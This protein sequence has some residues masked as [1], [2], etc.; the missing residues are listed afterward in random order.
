MKNIV[1]VL[2]HMLCGG[3]EKSL[4][5]LINEMPKDKYKITIL[6]V[7]A[8]GEFIE[9]IPDYVTCKELPI[10]KEIR[11]DLMLGG[12]K[13]SI[14]YH[15]KTGN[16]I[17]MMKVICN[18]ILKEPLATLTENFKNIEPIKEKYDI[19]ICYH[20][21]MPFIVRYVSEK[22]DAR[23]K[24]AWVHND[25]GNSGYKIQN[26]SKYME[27][28]DHCFCVSEQ[29]FNEFT[30]LLPSLN[31]KTS[32]SYNIISKRYIMDLAQEDTSNKFT[33][34]KSI[35]I[36]TIGR[37]DHQKGYD[38]AIKVCKNIINQGYQIKWFVL[39]SGEDEKKIRDMINEYNLEQNFILLGTRKNPYPYI[40]QCDI[41]VQTSRHEGYGIAIAEARV[42]CKAIVCT[43]FTGAREQIINGKTGTIVE[44][45]ENKITNEIIELIR[46]KEKR[47]YYENNLLMEQCDSKGEINNFLKNI[48]RWS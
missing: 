40:Q 32:I 12:I 29:L 37:L 16:L 22:I 31:E 24:L 2:P 18:V 46:N 17:K 33:D 15:M 43:D 1:F 27:R 30:N 10:S 47:R 20:V 23:R 13:K 36:L 34:E 6:L 8:E 7:K 11:N 39:G 48:D 38:M 19:A 26:I 25:F 35:K 21:H 42:L 45:D 14:M 9:L 28:Y 44:F 4:L 5:S 3:V 41:Y